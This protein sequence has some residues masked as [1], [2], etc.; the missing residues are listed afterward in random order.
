M[1]LRLSLDAAGEF[2][3]EMAPGCGQDAFVRPMSGGGLDCETPTLDLA[4]EFS[5]KMRLA[6]GKNQLA[7]KVH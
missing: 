3:K 5:L 2:G 7:L 6:H 1:N 4:L